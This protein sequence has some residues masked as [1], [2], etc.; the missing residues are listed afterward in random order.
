MK[1]MTFIPH[2]SILKKFE[3]KYIN[4]GRIIVFSKI[5]KIFQYFFE[6]S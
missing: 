4:V 2:P 3:K 1:K 5:F 6:K